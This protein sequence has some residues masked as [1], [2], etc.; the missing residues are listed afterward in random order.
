[1]PIDRNYREKWVVAGTHAGHNV[2]MASP[3]TSTEIH[4][5]LVGIS[6]DACNGC[7]RCVRVCPV[8]VFGEWKS[9]N[10]TL[11]ADPVRENDCIL[12]LVC[13][14]VCPTDAIDILQGEGS[15]ETLNSLLQGSH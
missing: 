12:C 14:T 8:D 1:M 2:W 7:M 10:G 4:G 13:E 11:V 3:K 5:T 6:L 15:D 9:S